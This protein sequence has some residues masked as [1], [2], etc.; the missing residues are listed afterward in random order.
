MGWGWVDHQGGRHDAGG[1]S[2]GTNQ[3][4]ELCA[5]LQALRAHRGSQDLIIESDSQYAINCSTKW[6]HGWKKNGWKNAKKQSVKNAPLIKAIDAELSA[7]PASVKFKWV[8]GHAG[9]EFNEK[10][11]DLAHGYATHIGEGRKEGYLPLEGWQSLLESPYAEGT[12]IPEDVKLALAGKKT[13]PSYELDEQYS[14]SSSSSASDSASDS[15]S[16]SSLSDSS[17]TQTS[18]AP[19]LQESS[20]SHE[21]LDS[22]TPEVSQGKQQTTPTPHAETSLKDP[23]EPSS[24]RR[25]PQLQASGTIRLS[26]PPSSSKR[27]SGVPLRVCGTLHIDAAIDAE[28][29]VDVNG[30]IFTMD[31]FSAGEQQNA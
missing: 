9:N 10:V 19:A 27:Y 29:Y 5:V 22:Q 16:D 11:D 2:N 21:T 3:I 4:G 14:D 8:K 12:D 31:W 17:S 18:S 7:R 6:V 13:L 20:S 1:A 23:S 25:K 30:S 15:D 26:P 28:G 24:T